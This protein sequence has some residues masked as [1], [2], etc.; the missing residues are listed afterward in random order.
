MATNNIQPDKRVEVNDS[1]LFCN[2]CQKRTIFHVLNNNLDDSKGKP[3]TRQIFMSS[4]EKYKM[5]R[6]L[7]LRIQK[8]TT[9]ID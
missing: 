2:Y 1:C 6:V 5:F 7:F 4:C 3:S 8:I 9:V